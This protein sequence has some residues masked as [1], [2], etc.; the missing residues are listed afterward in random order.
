[1]FV[2]GIESMNIN[3]KNIFIF[4]AMALSL[5]SLE[6][7]AKE[8][9]FDEKNLPVPDYAQSVNRFNLSKDSFSQV[10]FQV[11]FDH[12]DEEVVKFYEEIFVS[13]GW[14]VCRQNGELSARGT[15]TNSHGIKISRLTRRFLSPGKKQLVVIM[16]QK[17]EGEPDLESG[18]EGQNVVVAMYDIAVPMVLN[19]LSLVCE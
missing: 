10:N 7:V 13:R 19:M 18:N 2:K 1:M 9:L 11:G 14:K 3:V 8:G 16:V 5:L 15:Y 17:K 12:D 6:V 4:I